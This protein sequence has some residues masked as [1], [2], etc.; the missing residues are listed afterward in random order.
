MTI[1]TSI[2]GDAGLG[3]G[4]KREVDVHR[5]DTVHGNHSALVTLSQDLIRGEVDARFLENTTY[6]AAMN[7]NA[8]FGGTS[9]DVHNGTDA[10]QWTG[11]TLVGSSFTFDSTEQADAGTKSIKIDSGSVGDTLQLAKGS[12]IDLSGYVALTLRIYV[13][14]NWNAN[15][16]IEI[17]G[18]D[19]GVS[20]QVGN[21]VALEDYFNFTTFDTWQSIII[22][23]TDMGLT[24]ATTVDA[25]RIQIAAKGGQ[26][27]IFYLDVIKVQQ[28]GEPIIY[29][30]PVD[31]EDRFHIEELT[32]AMADNVTSIVADGTMPGL[33][34]NAVLGLGEL[35]NGF[36][37]RRV[38][39]GKNTF[40]APMRNIGDFL[41]LGAVIHN[42][43][44]D[45]TNT[46]I[47]LKVSFAHP[48]VIR[49]DRDD[50]LE[51]QIND[52]MSGLLRFTGVA[53]GFVE[54]VDD[55]IRT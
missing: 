37:I 43:I 44:S 24:V 36:T 16:S 12:D 8:T 27:P 29:S 38:K 50:A 15:D 45:G 13:D 31:N 25:F 3:D 33:S 35:T 53:K 9:D 54:I 39:G 41:A 46:F 1:R 7:Q 5:I 42:N 6:G 11:T 28:T 48:L 18:F 34:Y 2:I 23:L 52:D 22:P 10:V 14:T 49:G 47:T 17:Y 21:R 30:L 26:S 20:T 4:S 40:N 19:N 51:I 32:F 55:E